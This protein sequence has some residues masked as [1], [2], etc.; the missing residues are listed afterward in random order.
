MNN[1]K[2]TLKE[3]YLVLIFEFMGT[4]F[5]ACAYESLINMQ[6]FLAFFI[7]LLFSARIS[8][9]HYNPAVTLAFMF[10]R[11]TG[12][13]SK[14]LGILYIIVQFLGAFCGVLWIYN[15]MQG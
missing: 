2:E 8:G 14:S 3:S 9:S 13:F 12:Q 11:D 4:F 6:L 15:F 1:L 10:R 5:L 7:L